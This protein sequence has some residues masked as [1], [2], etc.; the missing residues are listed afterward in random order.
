M[1]PFMSRTQRLATSSAAVL[2]AVFLSAAPAR[3]QALR[4]YD[5][6]STRL[7]R[8]EPYQAPA[9]RALVDEAV[10][11]RFRADVQKMD[12]TT[13]KKLADALRQRLDRARQASRE[14]EVRHDERLLG[15][16]GSLR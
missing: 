13:R 1:G 11:E 10:Y 15:I 6:P 7:Q 8:A 2:V 12:P 9:P 3:P 14:A 16:L 4:P 5:P